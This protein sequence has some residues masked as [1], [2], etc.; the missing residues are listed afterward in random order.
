VTRTLGEDAAVEFVKHGLDDFIMKDRLARLPIALRRAIDDKK[1][2]DANA[3]V[4]AALAESES[5]TQELREQSAYGIFQVSLDGEFLS[6]NQALM[7]ILACGTAEELQK[8]NLRTE[9]FR[10]PANYAQLVKSCREDG[11]VQSAGAEWRRKDGGF[12]SVRLHLRYQHL[13]GGTDA[14]E[15]IVEDITELRALEQQIQRAQKFEMIGQLAGGVAHDFNNVVS[16]ILGWAEIGYEQSRTVPQVAEY[17]AHIRQQAD[18]AA[19]L[20]Q[21]LLAFS[22][23]Q[24]LQPRPVDLNAII[25]NVRSFLD[26]VISK[27][28]EIKVFTAKLD[29]VK[30]DPAQIE[31]VLM[32]L[33]LNARDA[34]LKGG[35][36][37]IETEMVEI[38]DSDRRFYPYL[39][40]GNFAVL[41]VS[42]T[43]VGMDTETRERIFEPFFTT[44]ERGKGTGMGLATVYGIVKQHGG[45]V[46]VYSE[47]GHGSLF[48]V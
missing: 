35:Q 29:T 6:V 12:I 27:E 39:K 19:T 24:T 32:N 10:Y 5:R 9:I 13:A 46:H 23:R 4:S 48:H 26:K 17:F 34:M 16:A 47:P 8:L 2:R 43:G 38:D 21:E 25:G 28:I 15:G 36:L 31:Q 30:A 37:V 41:S 33:C 14:L 20:T 11:L 44:K 22:H 1:L 18:R 40:P 7:Q 3:Q 45:F 42:D